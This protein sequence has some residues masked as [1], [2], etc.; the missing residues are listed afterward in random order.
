MKKCNPLMLVGC[1]LLLFAAFYLLPSAGSWALGSGAF[2]LLMLVCCV[3][4]MLFAVIS[5]SKSGCG[6]DEGPAAS[7]SAVSCDTKPANGS[8]KKNSR[9]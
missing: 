7:G 2:A 8:Q 1:L 5:G 6:H 9:H 3:G 4:P